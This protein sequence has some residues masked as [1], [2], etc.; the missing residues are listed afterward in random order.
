MDNS[1]KVLQGL[2]EYLRK[3]T[4]VLENMEMCVEKRI[5]ADELQKLLQS[6]EAQL[7]HHMHVV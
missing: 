2:T 6:F 4:A 3:R 7:Q 5:R 1:V